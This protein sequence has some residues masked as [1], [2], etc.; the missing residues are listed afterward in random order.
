MATKIISFVGTSLFENY[1]KIH[2]LKCKDFEVLRDKLAPF[3]NDWYQDGTRL[4]CDRI[5]KEVTKKP[6]FW[7]KGEDAS[8]EIK[9]LLKIAKKE[10]QPV[11][12]QLIA[13]DTVL[14]VLAATLIKKWFAMKEGNTNISQVHFE[15]PKD[16]LDSQRNSRHIIKQLN[17]RKTHGKEDNYKMGFQNLDWLLAQETAATKKTGQQLIF[18][19]T[20]GYKAVIPMMTLLAYTKNIPLK[21]MY[22]D[23]HPSAE[24]PLIEYDFRSFKK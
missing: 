11:E 2:K 21:Y 16:P 13:T 17:F 15:L 23:L 12:V 19:I 6:Q 8:A 20:A 7:R 1:Q 10:P 22:D 18:N 9:S 3:D 5:E 24:I 14:S 4:A